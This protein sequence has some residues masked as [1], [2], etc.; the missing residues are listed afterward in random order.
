VSIV[1][2]ERNLCDEGVEEQSTHCDSYSSKKDETTVV[3]HDI[4]I[5]LLIFTAELLKK[6]KSSNSFHYFLN[7]QEGED[8]Y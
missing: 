2:E 8:P 7:E 6:A 4:R 3:D 1:E 5:S